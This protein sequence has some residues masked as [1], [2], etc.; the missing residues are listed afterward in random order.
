MAVTFF[1]M[2]MLS[3]VKISLPIFLYIKIKFLWF[4]FHLFWSNWYLVLVYRLFFSNSANNIS[5]PLIFKIAISQR[6][7]DIVNKSSELSMFKIAISLR[8]IVYYRHLVE[9]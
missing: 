7:I 4:M 6:S 5:E 3:S 1:S 2:S 9:T 8:F